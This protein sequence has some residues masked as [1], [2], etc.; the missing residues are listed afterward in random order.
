MQTMK[1]KERIFEKSE[2]EERK[3]KELLVFPLGLL[4]SCMQFY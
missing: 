2:E 4:F 3:N 1:Q